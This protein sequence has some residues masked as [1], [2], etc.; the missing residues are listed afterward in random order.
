VDPV[1]EFQTMV[2]A[3]H[4]AGLEVILDV[5]F[6]HTAEGDHRGPALSLRGLDNASYYRL[7]AAE[8]RHYENWTG[9]GNTI[10]A[11]QPLVTALIID[12]LRWWVQAMH[13]DGFRFDLAPVL[14]RGRPA[15]NRHAAFFE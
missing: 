4:T 15:F 10:A 6:N 7:V 14:G 13:A 3:L 11:D 8:P 5:V 2:R 1:T 12:S 9:C